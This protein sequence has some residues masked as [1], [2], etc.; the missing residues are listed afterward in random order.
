[1]EALRLLRSLDD[2]L[3]EALQAHSPLEGSILTRQAYAT[4]RA[5]VQARWVSSLPCIA[6][7]FKRA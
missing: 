4:G 6:D 7:R 1:M 3:S 5:R 2:H